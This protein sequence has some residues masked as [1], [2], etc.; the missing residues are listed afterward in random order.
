MP[1]APED[2]D[3]CTF[4]CTLLQKDVCGSPAVFCPVLWARGVAQDQREWEAPGAVQGLPETSG[5][6]LVCGGGQSAP[7]VS[8]R[9][10]G[11]C[12]SP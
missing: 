11:S 6:R 7:R 4:F 8:R 2:G 1:L 10:M 5:Y 12:P 3:V 9:Q